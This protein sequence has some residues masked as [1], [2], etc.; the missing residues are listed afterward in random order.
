MFATRYGIVRPA[1]F[2]LM[3]LFSITVQAEDRSS[4]RTEDNPRSNNTGDATHSNFP[5]SMRMPAFPM[6]DAERRA[7]KEY[8]AAKDGAPQRPTRPIG[9]ALE[10]W[11]KRPQERDPHLAGIETIVIEGGTVEIVGNRIT[12][13]GGRVEINRRVSAVAK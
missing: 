7:I 2:T 4:S 13:Q 8:M 9:T 6:S 12:I 10:D 11:G 3:L 1:A 5:R